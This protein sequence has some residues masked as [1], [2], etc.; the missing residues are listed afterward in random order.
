MFHELI[1]EWRDFPVGEASWEPNS[2]TAVNVPE[3]VQKFM[4]SH[5]DADMVLKMRSL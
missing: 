4:E 2:V 5:G 3:M 1:V